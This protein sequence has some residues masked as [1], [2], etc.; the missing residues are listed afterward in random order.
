MYRIFPVVLIGL[1]TLAPL[2][3]A[4]PLA[5]RIAALTKGFKGT[6]VL[7][8]KNLG[9]GREFGVGA[10]TRV[11]TASTIKLPILCA[12]ESLVAAG[13]VK[14]DER[15]E[16]AEDRQLYGAGRPHPRIGR[17]ADFPSRAQ[18][19]RVERHGALEA[20]GQHGDPLGQWL[21]GGDEGRERDQPDEHDRKDAT[22]AHI[23]HR[24]ADRVR[25]PMTTPEGGWRRR[26]DSHDP[27]E[28]ARLRRI[29]SHG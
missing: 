24:T 21:G 1:V 8:A 26:R 25:G 19:L 20:L 23:I 6:A 2:V 14:W 5:D 16:R 15:F 27:S 10:D 18:V 12:L 28:A 11:R 13:K 3:A 17:D 7:Y 9:T 29:K 4:E 22:H